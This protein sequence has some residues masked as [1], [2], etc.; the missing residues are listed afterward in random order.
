MGL[1]AGLFGGNSAKADA[2]KAAQLTAVTNDRQIADLNRQNELIGA[3]RRAPRGQRL[4]E[5]GPDAGT[6][7]KQKTLGA[8]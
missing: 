1:L 6:G 3:T 2:E 5:D 8:A 7:G 4:F